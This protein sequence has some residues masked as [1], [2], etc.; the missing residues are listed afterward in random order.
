MKRVLSLVAA[1][2]LALVLSACGAV[3]LKPVSIPVIPPA[4]LAQQVC[5]I[6]QADLDI[7]SSAS[8]L[9]LL[10]AAQQSAVDSIKPKVSAACAAAATVDLTA[11]QS[12]NSDAF[13]AL[14]AIVAAVPAIPNQPAVLLALQLAQ[15]IVQEVVTNAVAAAKA[16]Q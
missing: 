8:G 12:F 13:P 4:Q 1:G 10:T 15:P 5:P 2:I 7:L 14:L 9:A 16:A 11:L 3:Q 6:V